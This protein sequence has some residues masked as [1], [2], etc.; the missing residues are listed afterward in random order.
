MKPTTNFSTPPMPIHEEL[1]KHDRSDPEFLKGMGH[2]LR[3]PLNVIIGIC[4]LLS[5]DR[6]RPLTPLHRDA[7]E[8]MERNAHTLL[9]SVNQLLETLRNEKA[10]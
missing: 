5:R 3:T 6:Q 7:V 1:I 4:Q 9:R 8:R 2:E 10:H